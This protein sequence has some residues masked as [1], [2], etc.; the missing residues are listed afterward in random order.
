MKFILIIDIIFYLVFLIDYAN[1]FLTYGNIKMTMTNNLYV[2]FYIYIAIQFL[3]SSLYVPRFI[4]FLKN[5]LD[6]GNLA[7]LDTYI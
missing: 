5:Y 3:F 6:C 1:Y 2:N 4:Y 7:G